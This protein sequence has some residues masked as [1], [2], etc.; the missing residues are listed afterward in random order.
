MRELE[1]EI[2][3]AEAEAHLLFKRLDAFRYVSHSD[4]ND[5]GS[6]TTVNIRQME[7]ALLSAELH[8][9]QLKAERSA[10]IENDRSR[11]RLLLLELEDALDRL[12]LLRPKAAKPK[13]IRNYRN[14][15]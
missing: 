10:L 5:Y 4:R 2:K 11:R 7:I 13:A 12:E 6:P 9:E 15:A 3:I 1:S 8:L 14:A